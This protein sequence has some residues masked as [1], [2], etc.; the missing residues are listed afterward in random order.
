[1]FWVGV[2]PVVF[3]LVQSLNRPGGNLTG[4]TFLFNPLI[5]KRLQLLHDLVP[6]VVSIGLLL[7]PKNPNA[8]PS[9]QHAKSAAAALGL[10][11]TVLTASSADEIEGGLRD[12]P[13][14]GDWRPPRRRRPVVRLT[15]YEAAGRA[16]RPLCGS[17]DVL[18]A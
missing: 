10:V 16:G 18:Q 5:E 6:G 12:G 14:E 1:V 4:V 15:I 13:R 7:N 8:A 3:G 9:E 11:L 2:D 17:R